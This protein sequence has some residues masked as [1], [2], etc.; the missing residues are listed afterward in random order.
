MSDWVRWPQFRNV[1]ISPTGKYLAVVSAIKNHPQRYQLAIMTTQSVV[2]G[3]P[4]VMSH[5]KMKNH[6]RFGYLFWVNDNRI[7][8]ATT[9]QVGGFDRPYLTGNLF[10]VNADGSQHKE[11]MTFQNHSRGRFQHNVAFL[12]LLNMLP[13]NPRAIEVYGIS[14]VRGHP[15]PTAYWLDVDTGQMHKVAES[16]LSNGELVADHNGDVRLALGSNPVTGVMEIDYRDA[17]SADWKKITAIAGKE[18]GIA[19]IEGGGPIMFGPNNQAVYFMDWANNAAET[20]GLYSYNFKTGKK[21]LIYANPTVGVGGGAF[22]DYGAFIPSFNRQSL[23]GLRIMPGKPETLAFN[24]KSRR[25]QLLAT[26]SQA[27]PNAQVEITSATRDGDEA[28]V[29]TWGATVSPAY[30]LYSSKPAPGLTILFHEVPWIKASDLSQMKPISFKSRDGLTIHGYLVLPRGAATQNLP[31]VVYVHGGPHGIRTDWGYDPGDFDSVAEQTLANHGYAV[32]SLNYRGSGGYGLKFMAAG[33]RHWGSTMQNDLADGVKWA[34]KQG[35]AN[36]KRICIFGASYGGYAAMMN[37]ER[38][39]DLY[40]C[41]VAYDGLYDLSTWETRAS[42]TAR[43]ASGRLYQKTVLGTN[44]KQ[45]RA[46]SPALHADKLKIPVFLL[47]GGR[48][49]RA[50]VASYDEMVAAIKK[51]GTPLQTLY[52]ENEG[53]GFYKPAHREKAWK[54]IL[55]FLGK[56]IGPGVTAS[57]ESH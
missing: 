57:R 1:V 16:P 18:P 25:I 56:Y 17:G 47:Q 4:R 5:Y 20:M 49:V 28:I 6:K 24:P 32:L 9:T 33:F 50:P 41:A 52:Y 53:H 22:G 51:H 54:D 37:S 42:D 46:F 27:L 38:F 13:K 43:Q 45:L 19:A 8:G 55:A 44:Q 21:K 15:H 39:P 7:A 14:T 40:Q 2:A 30:Y 48:D 36:P 3:K 34:I 35:Y 31:M 23:V 12:G 26:I 10:A 11:L 29:K